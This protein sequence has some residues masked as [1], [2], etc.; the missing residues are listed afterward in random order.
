MSSLSRNIAPAI[1]HITP[2]MD[3]ITEMDSDVEK[4]TVKQA[5]QGLGAY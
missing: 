1:K 3:N 4:S 5:P 2:L